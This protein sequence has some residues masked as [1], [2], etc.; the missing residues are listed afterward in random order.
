MKAWKSILQED[1]DRCF[2]CGGAG[3]WEDPLDTHHVFGGALRDKSQRLG[4]VV[5]LHHHRCHI[6]GPEAVHRCGELS[7]ALK[8]RA[9]KVL[10]E[11]YG[12]SREQFLE[13]FYKNYL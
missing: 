11:K 13:E 9:Q 12:L 4:L 7:R 3:S 10:E 1:P 8:A 2:L 6:F 5:R